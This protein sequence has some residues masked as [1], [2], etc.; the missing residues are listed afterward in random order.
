MKKLLPS[1]NCEKKII[2][3]AV[4]IWFHF[5]VSSLMNMK[6]TFLQMIILGRDCGNTDSIRKSLMEED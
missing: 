4:L 6:I 1:V 5:S 2:T 3:L